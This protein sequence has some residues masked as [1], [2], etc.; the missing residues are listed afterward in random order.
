MKHFA[1]GLIGAGRVAN[2]RSQEGRQGFEPVRSFGLA[3][4]WI[5]AAA[6]AGVAVG[7]LRGRHA[8]A[9]MPSADSRRVADVMVREVHTIE[10]HVTLVEAAQL[11]RQENVGALPIVQDGKV[12]GLITDRDLVVR[13][14]ARGDVELSRV[15]VMDCATRDPVLGHPGWMLE[16]ALLIMAEHQIGR[17]PV[18]DDNGLLVGLVTLSSVALRSQKAD[19]AMV[20]GMKISSRSARTRSVG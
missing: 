11:M 15:P 6:L 9:V 1:S 20:A 5:A 13:A 18:V 3:P 2:A 10:P 7:I 12:I 8:S 19:A 17:L 16:R 14:L 4:V